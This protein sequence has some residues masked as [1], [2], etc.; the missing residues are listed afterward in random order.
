MRG[1]K[2]NDANFGSRMVG[3]GVFAEQMKTMFELAR[4]KAGSPEEGPKLST[5]AFRPPR[6]PQMTLWE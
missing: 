5:D 3:E 4:R 1:G 2:L 6:G